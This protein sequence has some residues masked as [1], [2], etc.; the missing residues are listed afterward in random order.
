MFLQIHNYKI[1]RFLFLIVG[2]NDSLSMKTVCV[3]FLTIH[4]NKF[5]S[6]LRFIIY[7]LTEQPSC[8]CKGTKSII[9][10]PGS[11]VGITTDYGLDFLGSNIV[12]NEIICP[13]VPTLGPTLPPVNMVSCYSLG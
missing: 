8:D 13:S 7:V 3:L 12:G 11:S 6:V 2:K 1:N 10:G 5:T 4:F 9:I